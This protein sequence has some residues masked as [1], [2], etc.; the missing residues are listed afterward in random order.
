ME[1]EQMRQLEAVAR[2]G[3]VS[4][5]ADELHISQPALSRSIQRLEAE[6]GCALFDRAGR[7]VVLNEAGR[8]A[9]EWA[10]Q[11]LRDERLMREGVAA[12]ARR[13]RALHVAS[14][15]PAPVWR[16]TG[17]LVERFPQETLTSEL[18]SEETVLRGVADGTFDFGIVLG[19]LHRPGLMACELM[20]ENLSVTLPPNHPLAARGKATF[21]DLAG[22]SFLIMS[23]IGFWRGVVDREIPRA[24][25]IEQRD[26]VVFDQLARSTPHCTFITD[27][28]FQRDE[29][30]GR[31]VVPLADASAHA[32]FYLVVRSGAAGVPASLFA[33]AQEHAGGA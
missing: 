24:T 2:M 14:V 8:S 11:L 21:A 27:A 23:E 5:A 3:T 7:R 13:A 1:L 17:L 4:A 30:P 10:R 31:A 20:R 33:W 28:P 26:R 19:Q 16:L 29:A 22:E 32:V 6:L 25:Y 15:A 18:V 12:V 9:L